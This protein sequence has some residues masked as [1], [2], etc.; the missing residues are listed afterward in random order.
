MKL[1][2]ITPTPSNGVQ[3]VVV[4]YSMAALLGVERFDMVKMDCEGGEHALLSHA[5]SA[6]LLA[7]SVYVAC[8]IHGRIDEAHARFVAHFP[9]VELRRTSGDL[10]NLFAWRAH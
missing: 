10:A 5:P 4:P 7:K 8:E 9:H 6:T 1:T 3:H 2:C